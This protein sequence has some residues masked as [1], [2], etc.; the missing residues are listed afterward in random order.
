[1]VG[2]RTSQQFAK[3][4]GLVVQ[5]CDRR[6][7]DLHRHTTNGTVAAGHARIAFRPHHTCHWVTLAPVTK[8]FPSCFFCFF[9]GIPLRL[10]ALFAFGSGVSR[11]RGARRV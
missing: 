4:R 2:P 9:I 8:T 3:P 7:L 10:A 5:V 6:V 1:V 11:E